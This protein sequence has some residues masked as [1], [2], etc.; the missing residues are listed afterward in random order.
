MSFE[1]IVAWV[2]LAAVAVCLTNSDES[3][4]LGSLYAIPVA[5]FAIASFLTWVTA[6]FG[7]WHA[8]RFGWAIASLVAWPVA[9][10]YVLAVGPA[11][12]RA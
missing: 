2:G 7:A 10:V 5:I 9:F 12:A 11:T 6:V 8:R 3:V 1:K 4:G